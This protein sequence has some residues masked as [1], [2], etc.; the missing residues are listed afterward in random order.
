M[1]ANLFVTEHY[2]NKPP[3]GPKKTNPNKPNFT[4]PKGVKK[5][6]DA[7]SQRSDIFLLPF[8]F[9]GRHPVDCLLSMYTGAR[10]AIKHLLYSAFRTKNI[11][12]S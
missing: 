3:S 10:Y 7:G 8:V 2:E 11:W 4:Y 12:L 9:A 1:S 5:K 6:S